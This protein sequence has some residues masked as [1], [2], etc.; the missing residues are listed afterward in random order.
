MK[1]EIE[2]HW[3]ELAAVIAVWL[4]MGWFAR[5]WLRRREKDEE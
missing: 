3:A 4:L 5:R 2:G 1:G